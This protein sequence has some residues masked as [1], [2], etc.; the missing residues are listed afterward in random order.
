[1][2]FKNTQELAA[3]KLD[4]DTA[5]YKD[6]N[7][8]G[9]E[10]AEG[11]KA[12]WNTTQ[13]KLVT[14]RKY[15]NKA[16]IT[17]NELM[18]EF[19]DTVKGMKLDLKGYVTEMKAGN[20]IRLMAFFNNKD[21]VEDGVK[22]GIMMENNYSKGGVKFGLYGFRSDCSNSMALSSVYNKSVKVEKLAELG[23]AIET[24]INTATRENEQLKKI[25]Q[26]AKEDI[27]KWDYAEGL[28]S[29]LVKGIRHREKIKDILNVDI[30]ENEI[31]RWQLYNGLTNYS[32]HGEGLSESAKNK[33]QK[34][35]QQLLVETKFNKVKLKAQ[36]AK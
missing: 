12:I 26:K 2:D 20:G 18:R 22:P 21:A 29:I 5:K 9:G 6:V 23:G 32:T 27:L 31:T 11:Y 13:N 30:K 17:H 10:L 24:C 15:R 25:I 34:T 3:I 16:L 35:A 1:M 33:F 4:Y 8:N 19:T 28:L 14:I 36:E 7:V